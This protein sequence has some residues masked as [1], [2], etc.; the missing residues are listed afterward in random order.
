MS[1]WNPLVLWKCYF[2]KCPSGTTKMVYRR[3]DDAFPHHIVDFQA[4]LSS[5]MKTEFLQSANADAGY[6]TNVS[7][8]LVQLDEL[9][10]DLPFLFRAAYVDYQTD[11]CANGARFG[12]KVDRIIAQY[13]HLKSLKLAISGY[14]DMIREG[15]DPALLARRFVNLASD[16]R[17]P[18]PRPAAAALDLV[19]KRPTND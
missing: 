16:L 15:G 17:L 1:T 2:V 6:R 14:V 12:Q 10:G 7:A 11:P 18:G 13:Q 8:L 4:N 5:G 19:R 3:P 9:N